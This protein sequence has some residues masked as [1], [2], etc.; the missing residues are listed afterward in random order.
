MKCNTCLTRYNCDAFTA[1]ECHVSDFR[2]YERD[3][4]IVSRGDWVRHMNDEELAQFLNDFRCGNCLRRGN[5][6]FPGDL[7]LWLT[8]PMKE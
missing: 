5:N 8:Q 6:C 1:H 2:H 4:S 3:E 7:E